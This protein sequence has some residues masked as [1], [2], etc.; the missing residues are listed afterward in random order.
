MLIIATR[1]HD[2]LL[3][4]CFVLQN[5]ELQRKA[6]SHF[7]YTKSTSSSDTRQSMKRQ[8]WCAIFLSHGFRSA[9]GYLG[10]VRYLAIIRR[11]RLRGVSDEE[12]LLVC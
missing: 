1:K 10:S 2:A 8:I 9:S 3:N 7:Q 12:V 11:F 4:R 5:L 6:E